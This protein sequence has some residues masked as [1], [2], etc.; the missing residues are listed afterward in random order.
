LSA[1]LTP[2]VFSHGN[3][4]PGGTYTQLLKSLRHR[5]FAPKAVDRFGHDPKYPVSDNWPHLVQQLF[6]FARR[7]ADRSGGPLWLVGH[8]LGGFLSVMCA[9]RHPEIA[10]GVVLIDSPIIAGWR[11]ATL[12]VIKRTPLVGALTPGAV[13]RQRRN[14][15]PSAEA[16]LE[17]FRHKRAFAHWDAQALHDY[18]EHGTEEREGQ[19]WLRFDREIET[20]IYNTVPDNMDRLLQRRPLKC[21]AA[22]IGGTRSVEVRQV[23]MATTERITHGRVMM[24]EG[25]HLLPMEKPLAVAAAVEAAIRGMER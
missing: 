16:A 11:A 13:S 4:F 17:H 22:F 6:D 15:W 5:G 25:T 8:S 9:S 23:G 10:R 21:P 18:I 1:P 19:R 14:H 7:E 3:S 20:A 24:I 2:L 12:G